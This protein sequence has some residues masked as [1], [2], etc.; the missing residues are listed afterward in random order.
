MFSITRLA[1]L[2]VLA[3]LVVVPTA[4]AR[5]A[6]PP[7]AEAAGGD[8][9]VLLYPSLVNVPFVRARG[10]LARAVEYADDAQPDK[11]VAQLLV[12]RLQLKKAWTGEKYLI[13]NAPPPTP[14]DLAFESGAPIS[15]SPF[16]SAEDS[17]AELF[18]VY[19]E[20]AAMSAGMIDTAKG[21]L[22]SVLST[23]IFAT[24]NG[25]DAAIAYIHAN[26]P[27]PPPPDDLRADSSGAPVA[28]G[29]SGVMPGVADLVDDEIRQLDATLAV[30]TLSSGARRVLGAAELQD[31][32]TMRTINQWWPP[33]PVGD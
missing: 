28:A 16:A 12:V 11:A 27:P 20:V 22:Q 9:G 26:Q 21:T 32:K 8:L 14:G 30:K 2:A 18:N 6:G 10:A 31:T 13:D 17:G 33:A 25:R 5:S 7:V 29:W 4:T 19:H 1:V 24:L 15:A 3:A 23:T